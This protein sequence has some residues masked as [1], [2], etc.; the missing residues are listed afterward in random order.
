VLSLLLVLV[1]QLVTSAS[2]VTTQSG[3]QMDADNQARMVFDRMA[4]DFSNMSMRKDLDTVFYKG[5]KNDK[6]FFISQAPSYYDNSV[7]SNEKSRIALVGYRVSEQGGS[8][9]AFSL[10][11]L[12]KGLTWDASS[13]SGSPGGL[14]FTTG[15]AA[16]NNT[17]ASTWSDIGSSPYLGTSDDYQTL[18]DQVLRMEVCFQV[19]DANT[20]KAAYSNY[21][22]ALGAT[23]SSGPPSGGKAGDRWYDTANSRAYRCSKGTGASALWQPIG[24]QD[25]LG[26]VVTLV[27]LDNTSRKIAPDLANLI[28]LFPDPHQESDLGAMPP[29]LPAEIWE[30]ALK[31]ALKNNSTGIPQAAAAQVRIYQRHFSLNSDLNL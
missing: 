24:L 1:A 31:A 9:P 21:P 17:L 27:V 13:G 25:V 16:P 26:I 10:E 23:I 30:S 14:V 2:R 5:D 15:T 8:T 29:R 18:A 28:E 12:G 20:G 11:R 19:K 22:V 7:S 6:M 4:I 3:K